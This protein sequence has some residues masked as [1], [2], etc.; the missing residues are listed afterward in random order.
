MRYP[1]SKDKL[2]E[3][4]LALFPDEMI[5]PLISNRRQWEY[6]EPFFGAG[7]IGLRLLKDLSPRCC[8]WLNDIDQGM[9][10]YWRSVRDYPDE[11]T[12]RIIEFNPGR[13]EALACFYRFKREDGRT[14]LSID[15]AGF[16]KLVLHQFSFS[17]LGFK[18]G[19]PIGGKGQVKG[20]YPITC[21]WNRENEIKRVAN[22][23][24]V[25]RRFQ[26][27]RFTCLDFAEVI[28]DAP[29]ECFMYLDPP[30]V[31]KG[32]ELYKYAMDERDH[33]RLQELLWETRASWRLS[34][35]DH[36]LVRELYGT[37]ASIRT[38]EIVYTTAITRKDPRPK[39][40][41]V[42]I[43]RRTPS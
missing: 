28:C 34:Y 18:A 29:S 13:D 37:W 42:V 16:R 32:A 19:G 11:L 22:F 3:P 33:H 31:E 20:G 43:T 5:C 36:P 10:A 8:V 24:K 41:E 1:G 38:E 40:H 2:A 12:R 21:R 25:L 15:E 30:Y 14:D 39:N 7:A 23:G 4:I 26:D 6:R 35:D 17:G 27:F 9:V